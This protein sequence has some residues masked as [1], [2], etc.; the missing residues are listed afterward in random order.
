MSQKMLQYLIMS[1]KKKGTLEEALESDYEFKEKGGSGSDY[2]PQKALGS[3]Y[4][5][6]KALGSIM[7]LKKEGSRI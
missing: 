3:D 4:Q 2:K 7:S 6:E 1:L 5:L